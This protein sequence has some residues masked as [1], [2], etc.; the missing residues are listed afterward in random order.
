VLVCFLNPVFL[1]ESGG[2]AYFIFNG[3]EFFLTGWVSFYFQKTFASIY[4]IQNLGSV[5]GAVFALF[6]VF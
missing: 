1:F 4:F 3:A 6:L 5:L 2:G